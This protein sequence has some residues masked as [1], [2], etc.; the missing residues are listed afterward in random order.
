MDAVAISHASDYTL[1]GLGLKTGD[2]LS[3]KAFVTDSEVNQKNSMEKQEREKRKLELIEQLQSGQGNKSSGTKRNV[4]SSQTRNVK[5]RSRTS[6]KVQVGW[7]HYNEDQ[8]RY[9][10]VRMSR[11]GGTRDINM[12]VQANIEMVLNT[13]SSVFFPDGKSCF[14]N[15]DEMN[16]TV[17]N[18]KGDIISTLT[19]ENGEVHDFSV[20]KYYDIS[21]TN[22]A[23]LYLMSRLKHEI[24]DV[25]CPS[26]VD[27]EAEDKK[28]RQDNDQIVIDDE[29]EFSDSELLRSTLFDNDEWLPDLEPS[30]S[31]LIGSSTDRA[32]LI[33]EQDNAFQLS[34]AADL[35]KM[36][37]ANEES[38]RRSMET[39][40]IHQLR[41][42]RTERV[43]EEPSN[44]KDA[45][46]VNVRHVD[47]G[48]LSRCFPSTGTVSFVYDWIGSLNDL[49][50]NFRLCKVPGVEISPSEPIGSVHKCT[51]FMEVIDT[52]IFLSPGGEVFFQGFGGVTNQPLQESFT[53][54]S[55]EVTNEKNSNEK[56]FSTAY[57]TLFQKQNLAKN[58]L[59]PQIDEVY[60]VQRDSV[61]TDLLRYYRDG[62]VDVTKK[63]TFRFA[64]EDASGDG[65]TFD[66]VSCFWDEFFLKYCDGCGECVPVF[67]LQLNEQ[68]YEAI[69]KIITHTFVS[70]QL[71]PV[72]LG[73][74]LIHYCLFNMVSNECLLTSFLNMLPPNDRNLLQTS[75]DE[76]ST[77]FDREQILDALAD[78]NV[79]T[80]PTREN[81]S[82][83]VL[84]AARLS[85]IN[86]PLFFITNLRK[87]MGQF[88]DTVT[89]QEIQSLYKSCVPSA[90][91]V[92]AVLHIKESCDVERKIGRWLIRFIRDASEMLLRR[93]VQFC[94]SLPMLLPQK[95]ISVS[96]VNQPQD[97]L[98]PIGAT[99]FKILKLP[100]QYVSFAQL[101]DNLEFYLTN[102]HLWKMTE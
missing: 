6:K 22:R 49:P 41:I 64:N 78:F 39:Q 102:T 62:I 57:E 13:A 80:L 69:G 30:I 19:D 51:L 1:R 94:T 79:T 44:V 29:D 9:V 32:H 55:P 50:E 75:L 11:G 87:G 4:G 54:N 59:Q 70:C 81:L 76:K 42:E 48:L 56:E 67:T 45:V 8:Q 47:L 37:Q 7:M 58:L 25:K 26:V 100:R 95:K 60:E 38:T 20:R 77:H 35:V 31:S 23:R 96:F 14:G 43:P 36:Q 33:A 40:R 63:A 66:V 10:A 3:L 86:K 65:V 83:I 71:F 52:P 61:V 53:G 85:L 97:H 18:Y 24:D 91:R 74:A 2:I 5:Q 93:L 68:D 34:Q 99:C 84:N 73:E 72:R 21:K 17:G 92:I 15:L 90:E 88:W 16:C 101:K 46:T 12:S 82:S 98:R 28:E 27:K 89:V